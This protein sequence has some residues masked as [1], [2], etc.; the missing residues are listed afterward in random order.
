MEEQIL[1]NAVSYDESWLSMPFCD[2]WKETYNFAKKHITENFNKKLA[3]HFVDD[4][5]AVLYNL[6]Y[7]GKTYEDMVLN[8]AVLYLLVK[9]TGYDIKK[10]EKD[11][12]KYTYEGVKLLLDRDNPE[13]LNIVFINNDFAYL[14]KI[15]LAEYIASLDKLSN[16]DDI[17]EKTRKKKLVEYVI[18]TFNGK[19]HR[20]LMELLK[21]TF[22]NFN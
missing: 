18:K 20:G 14:N 11:Y 6:V 7:H 13:Y 17:V 3:S 9:K 10:I 1:S 16:S 2:K 22:K 21:Q 8:T 15:K 4:I 19:T 5:K 12:D